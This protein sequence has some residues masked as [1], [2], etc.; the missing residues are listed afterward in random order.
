MEKDYQEIIREIKTEDFERDFK[1][2]MGN[3]NNTAGLP[4]RMINTILKLRYLILDYITKHEL[5]GSIIGELMDYIK[6]IISLTEKIEGLSKSVLFE[7]NLKICI[8]TDI[9]NSNSCNYLDFYYTEAY[10]S[11]LTKVANDFYIR[12]LVQ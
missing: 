6:R 4:K 1:K 12:R 2:I 3:P 11:E 8:I 5:Q 10:V 7:N 9:F